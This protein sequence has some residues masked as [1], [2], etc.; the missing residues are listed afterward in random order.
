MNTAGVCR[1]SLTID[2]YFKV[3]K[4]DT[5]T[6]SDNSNKLIIIYTDGS[7]IGNGSKNATGGIGVYNETEDIKYSQKIVYKTFNKP[8]TN[9]ICELY[10]IQYAIDNYANPNKTLKIIT[11]SLYCVNIFTKW[12]QNW[13]RNNWKKRDNKPIQNLDMIKYIYS[14]VCCNKIVFQHCFSHKP[15]PIDISSI[16]HKIWLGN[17]IADKLATLI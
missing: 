11:D 5:K 3:I 1:Q 13:K 9:N 17:N 15:E 6:Y 16:E 8:V 12:A 14:K 10:A 4:E 2:K 7:S